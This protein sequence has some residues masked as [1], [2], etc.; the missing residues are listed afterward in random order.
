MAIENGDLRL[1]DG[2]P[3]EERP[4]QFM[5]A[6]QPTG[7]RRARV[8]HLGLLHQGR[9]SPLRTAVPRT[10]ERAKAGEQP[11]DCRPTRPFSLFLLGRSVGWAAHIVEQV[12]TGALIRP[13]ARYE[14]PE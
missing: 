9:Q 12:A 3:V 2:K 1:V 13:R 7:D 8:A 6:R 11:R 14:G 4:G 5:S 10:R